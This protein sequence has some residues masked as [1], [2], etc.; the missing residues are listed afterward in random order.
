[1]P[2]SSMEQMSLEFSIQDAPNSAHLHL[3]DSVS[4]TSTQPRILPSF[5]K[6]SDYD[7]E[8][9]EITA[10]IL[11]VEEAVV[12]KI[13]ERKKHG[14]NKYGISVEQSSLSELEWL[15]HAQQEAM[16]LAIYLQKLIS[17]KLTDLSK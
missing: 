15:V 10:N 8:R 7:P 5:S 14:L 11:G 13:Q 6:S 16:D 4:N 1:M 9:I 17:L 12:Y 2:K 3:S